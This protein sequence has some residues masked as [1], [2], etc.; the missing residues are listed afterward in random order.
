MAFGK[1]FA[2]KSLSIKSANNASN[3]A[4]NFETSSGLPWS[5]VD[6]APCNYAIAHLRDFLWSALSPRNGKPNP[7]TLF[8][9]I[10]SIAGM[11]N[12]KH[13][14]IKL[15]ESG[16]MIAPP[17]INTINARNG[18]TLYTGSAL[19]AG[20]ISD[21]KNKQEGL[22]FW[23]IALDA[24]IAAGMDQEGQPTIDSMKRHID[25]QVNVKTVQLR[26]GMHEQPKLQPH[27]LLKLVWPLAEKC[28]SGETGGEGSF[29]FAELPYQSAICGYVFQQYI[30][31]LDGQF[32]V[33]GA[34]TIAMESALYS[35][36][37]PMSFLD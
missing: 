8:C 14:F 13:V 32:P 21:S 26:S 24:A 23:P 25:E 6:Y 34:L 15:R 11:V 1:R 5:G 9:A 19:S 33:G 31:M 12:Q 20:L 28:F 29:G 3:L 22:E 7:E 27:D 4:D 16:Y 35:S 2:P 18:L 17:A 36:K 30:E 37:I 10:G